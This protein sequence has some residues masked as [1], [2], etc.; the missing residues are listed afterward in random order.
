M[1][2][3]LLRKRASQHKSDTEKASSAAHSCK[4]KEKAT[5]LEETIQA[6]IN[7]CD[8]ATQELAKLHSILVKSLARRVNATS[9]YHNT[10]GP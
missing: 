10:C 9:N 6:I 8:D 1:P 2:V 5:D 3:L 7:N 4:R